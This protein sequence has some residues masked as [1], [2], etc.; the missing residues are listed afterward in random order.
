MRRATL[1]LLA[2]VGFSGC[3][4]ADDGGVTTAPTPSGGGADVLFPGSCDSGLA[5]EP[6]SVVVTCADQGITVENIQWQA[7]G[8]ETATGNGTAQVN[9]CKPDCVAGALK[10]YDAAQLELTAIKDCGGRPQYTA[11]RLSFADAAPP[12]FGS[13]LSESFPCA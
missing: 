11:L 12:G 2:V 7:W 1:C 6:A 10:T 13:S 3:G 4:G 8:A 5:Q 9:D